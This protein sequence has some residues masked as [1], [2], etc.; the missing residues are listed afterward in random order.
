LQ[1]A[2]A[3]VDHSDCDCRAFAFKMIKLRVCN[4][5]VTDA[6]D[7][8]RLFSVRLNW[9]GELEKNVAAQFPFKLSSS[10]RW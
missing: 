4:H 8:R 3:Q 1:N 2:A 7:Q 10:A 5:V 6:C 9:N